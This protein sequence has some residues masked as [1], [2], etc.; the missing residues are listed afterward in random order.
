MFKWPWKEKEKTPLEEER[1]RI[2]KEMSNCD[3]ATEVYQ[4]LARRLT[5]L[6]EIDVKYKQSTK[7]EKISPNAIAS[8]VIGLIE[9]VAIMTYEKSHVLATKA[10][11]RIMR[12]RA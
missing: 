9:L 12:G 4:T 6:S 10:F 11:S 7:K 5:E 2:L 1:D 3:P 8:G